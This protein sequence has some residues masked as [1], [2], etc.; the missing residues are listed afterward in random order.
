MNICFCFSVVCF[1]FCYCF[2]CFYFLF[3]K[4]RFINPKYHFKEYSEISVLGDSSIDTHLKS[5]R[6]VQ[7]SSSLW[8]YVGKIILCGVTLLH[9]ILYCNFWCPGIIQRLK[10]NPKRK[11]CLHVFVK[12][13]CFCKSPIEVRNRRVLSECTIKS[14][15][16]EKS[17]LRITGSLNIPLIANDSPSNLSTLR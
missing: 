12:T 14:V 1:C 16:V 13:V 15:W 8:F 5:S 4:W 2:I 6:R 10:K 11:I 3:C 9:W 17:L 7:I